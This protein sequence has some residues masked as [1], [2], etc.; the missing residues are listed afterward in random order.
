MCCGRVFRR[1]AVEARQ[2][3]WGN[4]PLF[5]MAEAQNLIS[6]PRRTARKRFAR[7]R[8]PEKNRENSESRENRF[9]CTPIT[10]NQR[11]QR[12]FSPYKQ[13]DA[14][15]DVLTQSRKGAKTQRFMDLP[16]LSSTHFISVFG[17][18]LGSRRHPPS[19]DLC[20]FAS[21]RY[22]VLHVPFFLFMKSLRSA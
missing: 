4:A 7:R 13:M 19:G 9:F 6:H 8:D 11:K 21:L 16:F 15:T 1:F 12:C 20:V 3:R 17:S 10:Q 2:P 22:V 18:V 5:F 14:G